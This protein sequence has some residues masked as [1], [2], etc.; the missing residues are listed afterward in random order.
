MNP[1][2]AS[3]QVWFCR[4]CCAKDNAHTPAK[5]IFGPLPEIEKALHIKYDL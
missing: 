4:V 5:T 1:G 2:S 3:T